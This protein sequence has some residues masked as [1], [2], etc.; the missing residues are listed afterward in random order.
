MASVPPRLRSTSLSTSIN[1]AESRI[2][3][4]IYA[5]PFLPIAVANNWP[6][7][8]PFSMETICPADANAMK[9]DRGKMWT[10]RRL[11]NSNSTTE[12]LRMKVRFLLSESELNE[13]DTE[14]LELCLWSSSRLSAFF[15]KSKLLN[16]HMC[17]C[18]K[19]PENTPLLLY[20]LQ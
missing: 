13:T 5:A 14:I 4:I 1:Q 19:W 2:S 3:G 6:R 17:V 15:F 12:S 18:D 7:R 11:A 20:A 10:V 8:Q 9:N 16:K